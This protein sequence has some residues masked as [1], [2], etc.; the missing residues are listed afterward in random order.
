MSRHRFTWK[1]LQMVVRLHELRWRAILARL[2]ALHDLVMVLTDWA[3]LA[4]TVVILIFLSN[5]ILILYGFIASWAIQLWVYALFNVAVLVPR[6]LDTGAESIALFA[7]L[8]KFP[9]LVLLRLFAL[10][11]TFLYYVP[12]VRNKKPV[13]RRLRQ[14][15]GV[16]VRDV[17]SM[18]STW[19]IHLHP[20]GTKASGAAGGAAGGATGVG[21]GVGGSG[22]SN[23]ASSSSSTE[24]TA[25][26]SITQRSPFPLLDD[27]DYADQP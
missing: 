2:I 18:A 3:S 11:Y 8:Y 25:S 21:V 10:G 27:P 22:H 14:G 13:K 26:C 17:A 1:Y 19:G 4:Y 24:N 16:P 7:L 15:D 6:G 12:C 20:I 23:T 5:R 9:S